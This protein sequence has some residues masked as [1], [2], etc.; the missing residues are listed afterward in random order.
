MH[1]VDDLDSP[2][3]VG[4]FARKRDDCPRNGS[5]PLDERRGRLPEDQAT[6]EDCD[7]TAHDA[8]LV[9]KAPWKQ[10]ERIDLVERRRGPE[11]AYERGGSFSD[12]SIEQHSGIGACLIDER[13]AEVGEG[14]CS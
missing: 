7:I 14:L 5:R 13:G 2:R 1:D 4:R 10:D 6:A 12:G 9:R 3:H 11:V 8:Y